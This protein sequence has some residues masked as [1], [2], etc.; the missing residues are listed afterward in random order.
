M[1]VAPEVAS[2]IDGLSPERRRRDA[3]TL[4]DLMSRATGESASMWGPSIVA[5]GTYHYRYDSGREG[6]APAAGFAARKTAM[7]IY[8]PEGVGAHDSLL[9]TLGEHST[10]V[11]CLY[12]KHLDRVDLGVLER[13]VTAS[14]ETVTAGTFPHRAR[15]SG[16]GRSR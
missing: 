1:K 4:L 10:G 16:G 8:L 9:S 3:E 5:F 7:T 15:E 13:I 6:D 14:Y 2:H 11:G 12:V